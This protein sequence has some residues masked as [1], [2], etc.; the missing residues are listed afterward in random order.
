MDV[1]G[2]MRT[3]EVQDTAGSAE[4]LVDFAT[5]EQQFRESTQ[6]IS[7]YRIVSSAFKEHKLTLHEAM[8][9]RNTKQLDN[10]IHKLRTT[11][12]LLRLEPLRQH[13]EHCLE[14]IEED[15]PA[16]VADQALNHGLHLIDQVIQQVDQ[17]QRAIEQ[18]GLA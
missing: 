9:Q 2:E 14:L 10:L 4:S 11:V 17:R 1:G 16:D 7:F 15:S 13:L 5:A 3:N 8:K 6:K 12:V 18:A